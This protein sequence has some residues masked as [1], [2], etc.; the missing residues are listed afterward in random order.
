MNAATGS[1]SVSAPRFAGENVGLAILRTIT[2]VL[3]RCKLVLLSSRERR[4]GKHYAPVDYHTIA[5]SHP[6]P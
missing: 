4:G 1:V 3:N 2:V 6:V 5:Q